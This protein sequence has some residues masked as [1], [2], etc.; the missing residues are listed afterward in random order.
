MEDN[1]SESVRKKYTAL[2]TPCSHMNRTSAELKHCS[3][4]EIVIKEEKAGR[5][6]E[7]YP[8]FLNTKS[9]KQ[10]PSQI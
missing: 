1:E 4:E 3:N 9:Q 5:R 2:R 7:D 6:K 8:S 10:C